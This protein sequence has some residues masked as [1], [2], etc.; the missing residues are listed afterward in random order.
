[1]VEPWDEGPSALRE[2]VHVIKHVVVAAVVT[3]VTAVGAATPANA[4]PKHHGATGSV[5]ELA[6]DW[7]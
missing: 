4:A 5:S 7:E 3:T 2:T 1:M 6:I